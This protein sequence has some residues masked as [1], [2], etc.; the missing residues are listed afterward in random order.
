MLKHM[1]AWC[2]HTRRRFE[3][4]HGGVFESTPVF[5]TFFQRAATHTQTHTNTHTP[6]TPRPQRHTE[7]ETCRNN[8]QV[9]GQGGPC[10]ETTVRDQGQV[11]SK[12]CSTLS[13]IDQQQVHRYGLVLHHFELHSCQD[14]RLDVHC[15]ASLAVF[16]FAHAVAGSQLLLATVFQEHIQERGNTSAAPRPGCAVLPIAQS[17]QLDAPRAQEPH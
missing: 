5:T 11:H 13:E 4:T 17:S 15:L 14:I 12:N 3:C 2:R 1:Y 16:A 9:N 10:T 7:R 6:N 8:S